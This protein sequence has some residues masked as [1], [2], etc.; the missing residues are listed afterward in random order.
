[1][2]R[3]AAAI[4]PATG[5]PYDIGFGYLVLD[6]YTGKEL[7]RLKEGGYSE[8]VLPNFMPFVYSLH[9][10]LALGTTGSWIL[11]ILALVWTVDCFVGLYL[12][13]PTSRR[14]FVG[15]FGLRV[16]RQMAQRR[17]SAQL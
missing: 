16:A 15:R 9:T 2:L 8:G 10:S 4:D 14:N 6:P 11:S 12:T 7:G 17:L 1:M 5:K 3:C 13:L